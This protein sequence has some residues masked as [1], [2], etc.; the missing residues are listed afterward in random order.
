[1]ELR[2]ELIESGSASGCRGWRM[3]NEKLYC[4]AW[5]GG[6]SLVFTQRMDGGRGRERTFI[7]RQRVHENAEMK[8]D[9]SAS[10]IQSV[11]LGWF[12]SL[13]WLQISTDHLGG[14][15]INE[16]N[17]IL[18]L[19]CRFFHLSS[20]YSSVGVGYT[21]LAWPIDRL[22]KSPYTDQRLHLMHIGIVPY[23]KKTD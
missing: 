7:N 18:A 5:M 17:F 9:W 19:H 13:S 14:F 15:P 12:E 10:G 11:I 20:C 16:M 3:W 23:N 6:H 4:V 8:V 1:M 22:S 21:F 2:R